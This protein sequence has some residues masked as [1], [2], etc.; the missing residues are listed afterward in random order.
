MSYFFFILTKREWGRYIFVKIHT[1]FHS[2]PS[3]VEGDCSIW[4]HT[5]K[6]ADQRKTLQSYN[7]FSQCPANRSKNK[8]EF[9]GWTRRVSSLTSESVEAKTLM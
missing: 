7:C 2:N 5:Q 4:I 3:A 8:F 6:P 9:Q 1:K